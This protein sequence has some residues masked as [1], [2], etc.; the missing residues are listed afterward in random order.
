MGQ[1]SCIRGGTLLEGQL[2]EELAA[3]APEGTSIRV[4]APPYRGNAAWIGGSRLASLPSFVDNLYTTE[5]LSSDYAAAAPP[6]SPAKELKR[7]ER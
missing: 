3:I 6:L 1:C 2:E 5:D 7:E 4:L